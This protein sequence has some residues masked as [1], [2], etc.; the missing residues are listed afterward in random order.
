[1][2]SKTGNIQGGPKVDI[3][4][5]VNYC[6][7]CGSICGRDL[8]S[9]QVP[10]PVFTPFSF[11]CAY[12]PGHWSF[13]W[14]VKVGGVFRVFF[15]TRNC[16]FSQS[17][18]SG[19]HLRHRPGAWGSLF[20]PWFWSSFDAHAREWSTGNKVSFGPFIFKFSF[21]FHYPIIPD[22]CRRVYS[23]K[24]SAWARHPENGTTTFCKIELCLGGPCLI[25]V[26]SLFDTHVAF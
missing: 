17:S 6:E 26:S 16:D 21:A 8:A 24:G 18:L 4:Y 13:V 10:R 3:Q 25:I 11:P 5:I 15:I 7:P 23:H 1:M 9:W 19:P 14:I 22:V 2:I 20:H 12:H